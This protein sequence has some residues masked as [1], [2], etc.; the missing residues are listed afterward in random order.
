MRNLGNRFK[1]FVVGLALLFFVP[2]YGQ[3][4]EKEYAD[5]THESGN[6]KDYDAKEGH[7][8]HQ[9][10]K[11]SR[12]K[13][14]SDELNEFSIE[15]AQANPGSI[16]ETLSLSGEVIV[17]PN[18]LVHV[19]PQ[20][21]GM[22]QKVFKEIGD[23]VKENDLLA[24]LSSREL[25]EAKAQLVAANSRLQLAN[26]NLKRER[27]LYQKK[28]TAELEYLEAKQ[29]QTEAAIDLKSAK[30]RLLALGLSNRNVTAVLRP[31]GDDLTRYELRAPTDGVII[32]KHAVHGE[33]LNTDTQAFTIADLNRVWVNLA[34]YQK[35]LSVIHEGQAVLIATRH[36]LSTGQ[37]E[38]RGVINWVSPTL[39][40]S[41]RSAIARV[42]LDN[43]DRRWRPGLFVNGTVAIAE[44]EVE[45]VIPRSALQQVEDRTVVFVREGDEFKPRRVQLGRTDTRRVAIVQGLK[46]GETFVIKNAFTLKAQM[47]KSAFGGGHSH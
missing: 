39:S 8:E 47:S 9:R 35:D 6:H 27:E 14:S 5:N 46:P 16:S 7:S 15:L 4:T 12:L 1:N 36:G 41:T 23:S 11:E 3:S 28:V 26:A 34:V 30:Q 22:V 32:G 42:I 2:A 18:R 38:F 37:S 17:A 21:A 33:L 24:T 31:N 25:A 20:V 43:M 19:H 10:N 44:T 45:V 40:E 29:A 13:I